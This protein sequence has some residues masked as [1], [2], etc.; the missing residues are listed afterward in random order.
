MK[1]PNG[2]VRPARDGSGGG[3]MTVGW[4]DNDSSNHATTSFDRDGNVREVHLTVEVNDQ[5]ERDRT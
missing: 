1:I 2:S 3:A 5:K 4:K